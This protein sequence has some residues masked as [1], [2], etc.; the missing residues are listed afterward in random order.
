MRIQSYLCVNGKLISMRI[1]IR[2]E[3]VKNKR[4]NALLDSNAIIRIEFALRVNAPQVFSGS[5]IIFLPIYM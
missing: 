2:I 1:S 4:M 3:C 5:T